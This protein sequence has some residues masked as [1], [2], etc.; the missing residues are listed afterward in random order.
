L[1][2]SVHRVHRETRDNRVQLV[3]RVQLALV[4]CREIS[5]LVFRVKMVLQELDPLVGQE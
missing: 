5:E 4:D 3:Q 1:V 2:R